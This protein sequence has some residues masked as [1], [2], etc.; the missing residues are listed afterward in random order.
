MSD[1]I[2]KKTEQNL[3]GGKT[4]TSS[5]EEKPIPKITFKKLKAE[6]VK[7]IKIAVHGQQK[8]GK[9]RFILS[10]P[11]PIYVICTEPG[12]EPLAKLYPDKD[13][14]FI[15]CYEPDTSEIFELEPTKTLANIDAAV[16][17]L[18]EMIK[19]DPTSV[20]T[21]AIDSTSDLWRVVQEW[22]KMEILKIDRTARVRQQWDYGY[23]NTKY[24]NIIMQLLS[25]PVNL[26][27]TGQDKEEYAGAGQKTGQYE[28]TWQK[29]TGYWV[30]LVIGLVKL[31]NPKTGDIKYLGTIED[32]RHMAEKQ[33]PI[34]GLEIDDITFDKVVAQLDGVVMDGGSR[35]EKETT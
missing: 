19:E 24:E 20:R 1:N 13:I 4:T 17:T 2:W 11:A 35:K 3:K 34:A 32:S 25:L 8:V 21:I 15:D 30:D 26:V 10:C 16:K 9:S 18:R 12:L 7:T 23:A 27:L 5:S 14:Y 33:K 6:P 29:C 28:P 22:M 31:R